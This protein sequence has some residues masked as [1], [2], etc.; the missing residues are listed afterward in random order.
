MDDKALLNK[1]RRSNEN[2][3]NKECSVDG[4]G[5][6]KKEGSYKKAVGK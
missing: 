6:E 2:D 4:T 1:G 5:K 3:G